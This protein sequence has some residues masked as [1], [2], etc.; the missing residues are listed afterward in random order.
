[1]LTKFICMGTQ[2][3]LDRGELFV[4]EKDSYY[5]DTTESEVRRIIGE[6]ERG[7]QWRDVVAHHFKDSNPWLFDIIT[8]PNRDLFFQQFPPAIGS[9]VLDIG[10]GWGQIALPLARKHEVCAL[11]PTPER[12]SFIQAVAKQENLSTQMNFV[13]AD[14]MQVSFQTRFDLIAC[15]GVLEWVGVFSSD[16]APEV[17]QAKFLKK[18]RTELSDKG[19]C[20]IGIENRL[21][22][23]Y[24]MGAPDDHISTSD[25]AVFDVKLAKEKWFKKTGLPLR[26]FTY[27]MAEYRA[28]LTEAGFD[29]VHFFAAFPDYKLPQ[30]IINID[31]PEEINRFFLDDLY[32]EEHNGANGTRLDNQVEIK[33]HY[34]SLASM[35]IAHYFAPSF[36]IVAS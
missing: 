10:S 22:L 17:A 5:R 7:D 35:G 25:V 16:P 20:V 32:I 12:M 11:E 34:K 36:F 23:K 31:T 9:K 28:L 24:I 6:I 27:T 1:M 2:Q 33:S 26:S 18:I 3:Q 29:E 15:I 21:G 8:H 13:N 14:Y 4:S 30:E 19:K